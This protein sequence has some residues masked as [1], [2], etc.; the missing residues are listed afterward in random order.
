M[1]SSEAKKLCEQLLRITKGS[2]VR[3]LLIKNK[4][5]DKKEAWREYGDDSMSWSIVGGQG[6]ADFSLN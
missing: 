1:N 5:W 2:E 4:L 3:E 6:D